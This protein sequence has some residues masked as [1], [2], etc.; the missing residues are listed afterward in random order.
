MAISLHDMQ[1]SM[2]EAEPSAL[3]RT[4]Y[5]GQGNIHLA[6]FSWHPTYENRLL[7]ISQTGNIC[8]VPL[9]IFLY[10][11]H[12]FYITILGVLNDYFVFE[13]MTLNWSTNSSIAWTF[14]QHN[15]KYISDKD[16]VYSSFED[17]STI[18][19]M[20]AFSQYG[21]KVLLIQALNY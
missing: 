2:D 1:Q 13:R 3:E 5:P 18:I 16:L 19:K 4:V 14:G 10:V 15:L 8:W 21:I 6:S 9:I 12:L 17:I 20:R 7:A 11:L